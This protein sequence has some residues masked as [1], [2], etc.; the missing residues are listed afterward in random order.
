MKFLTPSI[1]NGYTVTDSILFAEEIF[2][3]DSN[4]HMAT[5]DVDSLFTNIPL[6]E[7]IDICFDNLY[8]DKENPP[9]ISKHGFCNLLNIAIKESFF[10]FSNKYYKQLDGASLE[11]P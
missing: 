9:N 6:N 3:Q 1:A 8:N 11:S 10:T 7:T 5:L 4:L 2:Q